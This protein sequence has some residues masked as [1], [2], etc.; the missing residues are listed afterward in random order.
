MDRDGFPSGAPPAPAAI[1]TIDPRLTLAARVALY[2]VAALSIASL[3]A[4]WNEI[5]AFDEFRRLGTAT[6]I[7]AVADAEQ[8][9]EGF[10]TLVLWVGVASAVLTLTW[11][12]RAYRAIATSGAIGLRW[13]PGWAVGGWFI[14]IGNLVIEK[15]V[16][17]EIDRVSSAIHAGEESWRSRRLTAVTGW[18]W[19]AWAGGLVLG[20]Y[21][22]TL[23]AG[24]IDAPAFDAGSYRTGLVVLLITHGVS[25]IA[26]FLG[27]ASLRVLGER[28]DRA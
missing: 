13:S 22:T 2:G 26:A 4:T 7:T 17:D 24:Q 8:L 9:S 25:T 27:A 16:L 23:V 11:W 15:M 20:I 3:I 18:W 6:S 28:L 19:G 12:H 10:V 21:G 1:R 14:P 5:G